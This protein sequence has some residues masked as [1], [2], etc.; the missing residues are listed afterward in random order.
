MNH[1]RTV[2]TLDIVKLIIYKLHQTAKS[3]A[4]NLYILLN[5]MG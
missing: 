1:M 3:E 4:K 2:L 5:N